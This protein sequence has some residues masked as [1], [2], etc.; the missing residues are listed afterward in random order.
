MATQTPDLS[1]MSVEELKAGL[2]EARENVLD[3]GLLLGTGIVLVFLDPLVALAL[4]DWFAVRAGAH[5][6]GYWTA[7][8]LVQLVRFLA[9]PG[10]LLPAR[11]GKRPERRKDRWQPLVNAYGGRLLTLAFGALAHAAL[12]GG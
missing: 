8:G 1:G 7:F 12:G 5:R 2:A 3:V 9:S 10:S 6:V 4:W 11:R